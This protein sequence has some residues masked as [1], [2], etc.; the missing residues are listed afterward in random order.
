[1]SIILDAL[2]KAETPASA[3]GASL[4]GGNAAS[5]ATMSPVSTSPAMNTDAQLAAPAAPV[6]HSNA[7]AS[8]IF[9]PNLVKNSAATL[10]RTRILVLVLIAA[11]SIAA[12]AYLKVYQ[13]QQK[14]AVT[15]IPAV[16]I[17]PAA[18]P[19]STGVKNPSADVEEPDPDSD[20]QLKKIAD[21]KS[22]AA[23]KFISTYFKEA[24]GEY[25]ELLKIA[26]TD[27]EV[28]NNYGVTLKRLNRKKDAEEAYMS[29]ID[30]NPN[31]AEAYNNLGVLLIGSADYRAAKT[32]FEKA[33]EL[34]TDFAEP[35]LHLGLC[36]EKIGLREAAILTYEK[37]IELAKGTGDDNEILLH[38]ESRIAKLKEN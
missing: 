36:Q 22:S 13:Q 35:Y 24:A 34:R 32:K 7:K 4:A 1:M 25:E 6:L 9:K 2:K 16:K 23:S 10:P 29:A 20:L 17:F 11:L 21:L 28:Y 18:Q 8:G 33:I 19:G 14:P 27:A 31:Y 15:Q 3:D 5:Q 30:L 12:Y 38:V 37:Y 26:P